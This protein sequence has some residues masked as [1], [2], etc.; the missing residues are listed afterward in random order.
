[1]SKYD[2]LRALIDHQDT[3]VLMAFIAANPEL[4]YTRIS[5]N[6]ASA[7]WW[8][9][10]PPR[11]V[12]VSVELVQG[13]LNYIKNDG[14]FLCN[15]TQA[16][17]SFARPID[18]IKAVDYL[19]KLS[20]LRD[21]LR[22]AETRYVAPVVAQRGLA[23]FA[24]D[25]QSSHSPLIT[26]I[27]H[28]NIARLYGHY[29]Q[30][31]SRALDAELCA[32][33]QMEIRAFIDGGLSFSEE[34]REQIKQGL[35]FCYNSTR[36]F[37]VRDA[38]IKEDPEWA[39]SLAQLLTLNWLAANERDG[40]LL[41]SSIGESGAKDPDS[42]SLS[43]RKAVL[44]S[45]FDIATA[46]GE[47]GVSCAAGAFA[48]FGL[49]L[50]EQHALVHG[51]DRG[52]RLTGLE[53][54][55]AITQ[56]LSAA[57]KRLSEAR[58]MAVIR[59]VVIAAPN[60]DDEKEYTTFIQQVQPSL[61]AELAAMN[62][63]PQ[64]IESSLAVLEDGVYPLACDARSFMLQELL[65]FFEK[66]SLSLALFYQA[67]PV[68]SLIN[69]A[70]TVISTALTK[71]ASFTAW[72][73]HSQVRVA[74]KERGAL[75]TYFIN[76]WLRD[77]RLQDAPFPLSTCVNPLSA[78]YTD[79]DV[80]KASFKA[81][82][83]PLLFAAQF[84]VKKPE[85]IER[86][87]IQERW[88]NSLA[89]QD[90]IALM[91]AVYAKNNKI[92]MDF[93]DETMKAMLLE[94][95]QQGVTAHLSLE[96]LCFKNQDL[97]AFDFTDTNLNG[98]SFE[99]CQLPV[100][101][102]NLTCTDVRLRECSI[103]NYPNQNESSGDLFSLFK[104]YYQHIESGLMLQFF[105][106][107]ADTGFFKMVDAV[108]EMTLTVAARRG[109][110]TYLEVLLGNEYCSEDVFNAQDE[111]G[112][113]AIVLAAVFGHT[114][115]LKLLL[116]HKHCSANVFNAQNSF[117]RNAV[118]IATAKGYTASLEVLLAHEY[119]SEDVFN[120][121]DESG[122]SAIVLAAVFGHTECLKLLLTHKHCSANV[123]NAQN[124][125]GRNAV[126]IATVKGY[127]A[128]LEVLLAHEYCSEDV[129]NARNILG[130]NALVIAAE[131]G[132]TACLEMLLA[133]KHCSA[134][135]FNAQNSF[136]RNAV[137]IATAKGYTAS[138][139]VLLAHEYCSEDVLNARNIWGQ[140]ALLIA[141]EEGHTA[142][143][144]MLL[145]HK[146]CSANV[147]NALNSLGRNAVMIATVK[148]Y[149]AS[150]EVLLAHEYCSEDVLNARNILG[151]N[152][153]VIAA[154][155]GHTACLEMLLAHKH[156]SANVF[157]AQNSFGR[158]AVMIA[159][160]KGYTASL[161]VLL[162]HEYCSEDVLNAREIWGQNALWIA[163]EVGH[164]ACLEMLLAHKHCSADFF[165]QQNNLDCSVLMIAARKGHAACLKALLVHAHCS[166]G[167]VNRK[168]QFFYSQSALMVAAMFGHTECL[169]VLLASKHCS[170]DAFNAKNY[171][172]DSALML[173]AKGRHKNCVSALLISEHF[174][175]AALKTESYIGAR[176]TM[177]IRSNKSCGYNLAQKAG[178]KRFAS[179][180][181]TNVCTI[182]M[183]LLA[184]LVSAS[185]IAAIAIAFTVLNAM[186]LGTVGTTIAC[187]GV[188]VG[189]AVA[190][191]LAG[192]G[193]FS[194]SCS[195]GF[196]GKLD[197]D[198]TLNSNS[199]FSF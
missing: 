153:L 128:S 40:R 103:P 104:K 109:D 100:A 16:F 20:A 82:V 33:S 145:A 195:K 196:R 65:H 179:Q 170:T 3:A 99:R 42:G 74:D 14:N 126:M 162:A 181:K 95:L 107:N 24:L 161:E 2:E 36:V 43:R 119:C 174:T 5:P 120:A 37:A 93:T 87:P 155:E 46:Y 189:V 111:S 58:Y 150:L 35:D 188:G 191:A 50:A 134:N 75:I 180:N 132:H 53:A 146:H 125:F 117:G 9:L 78:M 105:I 141:A 81:F 28:A 85:L 122:R 116:T 68:A 167:L 98:V 76:E 169:R 124:S 166:T 129:L 70:I 139:E 31:K 151:Q 91:G 26:P 88:L 101:G 190:V 86:N 13:L 44:D 23:A 6:G 113:S 152:A 72:L 158:N 47:G 92:F 71:N 77:I 79:C 149:T 64:E 80:L 114:E 63:D 96:K 133:H 187:V 108:D 131:E 147:F 175:K 115:C 73:E 54:R 199:F 1:M 173:A 34:K 136:G 193:V 123:F 83:Q 7:L 52:Q 29:V 130:Q 12:A 192:L 17:A 160:A 118:M 135:V 56:A 121:Q 172:G 163:A 165:N 106:Q 21:A 57:L 164:T 49:S 140:N 148:G 102:L 143:L 168:N 51:S 144:E 183:M 127:T 39:L 90:I 60:F 25:R 178:G 184:G 59:Y 11:G 38:S 138:L 198:S 182:S 177:F 10:M 45:L 55:R 97:R 27:V 32:R 154:E 18:Y 89:R 94:A 41:P 185:G 8:A 66:S 112:R 186:T 67:I 22:A 137:M 15:P 48:R 19:H 142:C 157:N 62:V 30:D 156:C 61:R 84:A 69:E 110:T 4:N 159:T 197:I 176:K 194:A 171:D